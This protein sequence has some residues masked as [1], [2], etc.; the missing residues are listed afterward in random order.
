M[1]VLLL[2]PKTNDFFL[3][4]I[5]NENPQI[6]VRHFIEKKYL[7]YNIVSNKNS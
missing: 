1:N 3:F 6:I 7:I 2:K 5:S 4:I